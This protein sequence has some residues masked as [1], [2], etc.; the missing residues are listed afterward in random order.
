MMI[1]E[2]D[3]TDTWNLSVTE[4]GKWRRYFFIEISEYRFYEL[5]FTINERYTSP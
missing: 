5:C 3:I 2:E 4:I 1:V